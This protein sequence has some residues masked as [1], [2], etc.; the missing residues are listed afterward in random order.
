ME[1]NSNNTKND[2]LPF[3]LKYYGASPAGCLSCQYQ[4]CIEQ[5]RKLVG[6]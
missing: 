4:E 6:T 1:T 3:A 2:N 5:K